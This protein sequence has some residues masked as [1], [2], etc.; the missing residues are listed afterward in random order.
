MRA[1]ILQAVVVLMLAPALPALAQEGHEAVN[2]AN[3]PLTPKITI[4]FQNY[5]SRA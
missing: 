4:N 2:E 3:N 5:S 1:D